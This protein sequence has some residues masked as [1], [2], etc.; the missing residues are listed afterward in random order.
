MCA[1]NKSEPSHVLLLL[2]LAAVSEAKV[3]NGVWT[4]AAESG[5]EAISAEVLAGSEE[6]NKDLQKQ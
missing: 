1:A 4:R 2:Q 6:N 5:W 3:V